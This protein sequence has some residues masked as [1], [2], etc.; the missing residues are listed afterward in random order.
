MAEIRRDINQAS[1]Q[2]RCISHSS[3]STDDR[4]HEDAESLCPKYILT[5]DQEQVICDR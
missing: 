1:D 5:V 3:E 2:N 4:G